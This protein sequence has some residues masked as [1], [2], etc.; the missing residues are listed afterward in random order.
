MSFYE[1]SRPRHV[2]GTLLVV[3][4]L[5]ASTSTAMCQTCEKVNQTLFPIC[6]RLAGYNYTI[7]LPKDSNLNQAVFADQAEYYA[8]L[9]AHGACS[10][11]AELILCSFYG[12]PKCIEGVPHAVLPCRQVCY[13]FVAEC[14]YQLE[15][16][17][18]HSFIKYCDLLPYESGGPEKCVKPPGFKEALSSKRENKIHSLIYFSHLF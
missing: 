18:I 9:L 8:A 12:L 14:Q 4:I 16:M 6:G 11:Y 1:A 10:Q 2:S 15:E 5:L 13:Q 17:G 7:G 3:L